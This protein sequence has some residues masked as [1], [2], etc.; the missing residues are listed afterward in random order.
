MSNF[1]NPNYE[2][3]EKEMSE[4]REAKEKNAATREWKE[5]EFG[6]KRWG[7]RTRER[8]D[9]RLVGIGVFHTKETPALI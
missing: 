8:L 7:G 1:T 2:T 3:N 6:R 9:G 4:R 5:R